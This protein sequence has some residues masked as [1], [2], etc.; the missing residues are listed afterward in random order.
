MMRGHPSEQRLQRWLEAESGD[1]YAGH[2]AHCPL[3][4]ERLEQ[5]TALEPQVREQLTSDLS[6]PSTLEQRIRDHLERKLADRETMAVLGELMNTGLRT[7]QVLLTGEQQEEED[8]N[9]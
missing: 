9:G 1:R 2:I 6:A 3:C 8:D 4:Q 7:S 5:M